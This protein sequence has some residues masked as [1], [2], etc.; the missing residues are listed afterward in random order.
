MSAHDI[1]HTVALSAF[2][3]N[4]FA[5]FTRHSCANASREFIGGGR[6]GC[7]ESN[8]PGGCGVISPIGIVPTCTRLHRVVHDVSRLLLL[9]GSSVVARAIEPPTLVLKGIG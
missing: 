2:M 8:L 9:G 5:V 6:G 1:F 3:G 4:A 7:D